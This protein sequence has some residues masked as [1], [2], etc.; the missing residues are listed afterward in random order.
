MR[1]AQH[2]ALV[3]LGKGMVDVRTQVRLLESAPLNPLR[4]VIYARRCSNCASGIARRRAPRCPG[5][6]PSRSAASSTVDF[7]GSGPRLA[8]QQ[9]AWLRGLSHCVSMSCGAGQR[10]GQPGS[11][12]PRQ[13]PRT[14]PPPLGPW[15]V[16]TTARGLWPQRAVLS[17]G[18]WPKPAGDGD[19][20]ASPQL[21]A[22]SVGM[23]SHASFGGMSGGAIAA[24]DARQADQL[25]PQR[26]RVACAVVQR[27]WGAAA[28][29]TLAGT[30]PSRRC[31]CRPSFC[32]LPPPGPYTRTSARCWTL[33]CRAVWSAHNLATKL[34][35]P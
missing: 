22:R 33:S 17:L 12:R 35:A 4:V 6:H 26:C 32:S 31:R 7:P 9:P 10:R 25:A 30:F 29:H 14:V 19:G 24:S 28:P 2:A 8:R 34:P 13:R 18:P 27:R 21:V 20:G 16:K 23:S 15:P 1:D 11:Q 3:L 5:G